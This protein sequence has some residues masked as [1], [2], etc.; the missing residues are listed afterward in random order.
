MS[1]PHYIVLDAEFLHDHFDTQGNFAYF[2]DAYSGEQIVQIGAVRLNAQ[3]A[4][5]DELLLHIRPPRAE[6]FTPY[7]IELFGFTPAWLD[8]HGSEPQA[9]MHMLAAFCAEASSIMTFGQDIR[10]ISG[11]CKAES[12]TLGLKEEQFLN[13]KP[14]FAQRKP[15]AYLRSGNLAHMFG[16]SNG[17]ESLHNALDDAR[18]VAQTIAMPEI[19]PAFK[20]WITSQHRLVDPLAM[21]SA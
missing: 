20:Q 4:I 1:S 5:T 18:S 2:T 14:F 17:A 19:A 10:Y 8:E 7:F 12:V 21:V 6:L 11:F 16:A 3:F 9:A 13:I 15:E